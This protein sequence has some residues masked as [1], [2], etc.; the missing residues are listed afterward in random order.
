MELQIVIEKWICLYKTL[1]QPFSSIGA[2]VYMIV[3]FKAITYGF[4][5]VW[6]RNVIHKVI[7]KNAVIHIHNKLST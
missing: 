6:A 2:V 4:M 7:C 1:I 3:V 5:D